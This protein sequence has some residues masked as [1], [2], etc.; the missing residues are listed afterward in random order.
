MKALNDA[1]SIR[2]ADKQMLL[3]VK[4]A[5]ME[6]VPG[7]DLLLYGS[8]ARGERSSESDYDI[9]VLTDGMLAASYQDVLRGVVYDIALDHDVVI[10]LVFVSKDHWQLP[11]VCVTPFHR[12][13]ESEGITL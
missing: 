2:E 9:L 5:I 13:V 12:N 4:R 10:S 7:A 6:L 8:T 3:D 11:S 1:K